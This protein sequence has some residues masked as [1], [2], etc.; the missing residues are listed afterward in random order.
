M[1]SNPA[2]LLASEDAPAGRAG[3]SRFLARAQPARPP[4]T[5]N[6]DYPHGGFTRDFATADGER[7][8]VAALNPRQ[9]ADLAQVT[10]LASTFAFLE[11][12][13]DADFSA[14]GDLHTHRHTIAVLLAPWF[15]RR[16]VA[17]LAT[18]F[19]G[20][21]VQGRAFRT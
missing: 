21:S 3:H 5:R 12:L 1:T 2:Q 8:T 6:G 19:A 13:L 17:D 15:A 9:F 20:T 14:P 11:R 18:A 4:G 16:T 7:V 10:R